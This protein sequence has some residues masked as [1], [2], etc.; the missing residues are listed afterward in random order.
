MEKVASS[1]LMDAIAGKTG[2][3]RNAELLR[4]RKCVDTLISPT[5]YPDGSLD[6]QNLLLLVT[7]EYMGGTCDVHLCDCNDQGDEADDDGD[8]VNVSEW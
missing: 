5:V 1:H 4:F 6:A 2:S 3:V 8:Q 7:E